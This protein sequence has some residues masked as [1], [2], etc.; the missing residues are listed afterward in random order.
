MAHR[1]RQRGVRL[2]RRNGARQ[3]VA[4]AS[5]GTER[6]KDPVYKGEMYALY[7]LKEYQRRGIGRQL[8]AMIARRLSENGL[9]NMLI[10]VLAENPACVFYAALG[11]K[12]A[13]E[14]M[15]AIGGKKLRE[16]GYGWDD[17]TGLTA[18]PLAQSAFSESADIR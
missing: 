9:A 4:F 13:R 2:C 15:I 1:A 12:P 11:G 7:V 14:K 17:L 6:E 16:V 18:V 10:W 8:V 5:A 3:I